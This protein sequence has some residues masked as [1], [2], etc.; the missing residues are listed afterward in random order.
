[1]IV[2]KN[3]WYNLYML[4]SILTV[5]SI[6]ACSSNRNSAKEMGGIDSTVIRGLVAKRIMLPNGWSLTPAGHSLP[7][8]GFPMTRALSPSKKLLAVTNNG[9]G[10]QTII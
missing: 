8:G 7:L 4:L 2:K 9:Y 3:G 1:M 6:I 5:S 10:K